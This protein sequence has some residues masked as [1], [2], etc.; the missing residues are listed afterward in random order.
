M[1]KVELVPWDPDS[2]QQY[3][4]MFDQRVACGWRETEVPDWKEAQLK[5]TKVL[6]WIVSLSR[7]GSRILTY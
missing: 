1:D 5:R 3:E 4:R 6:Y 7:A 2:N